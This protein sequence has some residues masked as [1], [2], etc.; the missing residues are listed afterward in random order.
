MSSK[1]FVL[2]LVL[3]AG[4]LAAEPPTPDPNYLFEPLTKPLTGTQ[5][6]ES[7]AEPEPEPDPDIEAEAAHFRMLFGEPSPIE[8]PRWPDDQYDPSPAKDAD[9]ER[10]LI[11]PMP[12]GGAMVFRRIDTGNHEGWLGDQQIR[13]GS[14]NVNDAPIDYRYSAYIAGTFTGGTQDPR[15]NRYYYLGKYE[16]TDLQYRV[17]TG[18]CPDRL[19]G[20]RPA[21]SISWYD[22]VDFTR[23][24]T[25]WLYEM[26]RERLPQE[27]GMPGYLRLPTEVEWEY[28]AR[29]GLEVDEEQFQTALFPMTEGSIE[30]YAWIRESVSSSF[31]PRPSGSLKPNPLGLYDM[32]GNVSELVFD[33]FRLSSQ[34]HLHGQPGGFMVKGGHFRS[35]RNTLG[36]SWRQEHPHF[37][38]KTGQPNR[39]DTVGFRVAISAPVLTSELRIKAIDQEWESL[40]E[41][42]VLVEEGA[43]QAQLSE[44]QSDLAA[45]ET[46]LERCLVQAGEHALPPF[47]AAPYPRVEPP[48]RLP[49]WWKVR[50]RLDYMSTEEIRQHALWFLQ[51]QDPDKALLLFKQAARQGEAWSALAIGAMYDPRLFDAEDFE[52]RQ[53]AFSKPNP[54]M[55]RCWYQ[56][57]QEL[58]E[59]RAK[60]HLSALAQYE[61]RAAPETTTEQE[62]AI[63]S[64]EQ[65]LEQ[66][67][68]TDRATNDGSE[69]DNP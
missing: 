14:Q 1:P 37:N 7:E 18:P 42:S 48:A 49:A 2:A 67:G 65:I 43:C 60:L 28:A 22:A 6:S 20:R 47:P 30:D 23:R 52:P 46:E 66:Y 29:G 54:G 62:A 31:E 25:E 4:P 24:Y 17:M 32:L 40:A 27:D 21:T 16:V 39:L 45:A 58:G 5:A 38:P 13:L 51:A 41:E 64:C 35:W 9:K 11:L 53:S 44:A 26:A 36:S 69:E 57:S 12:C 56:L 59:W 3:C 68:P 34:G 55:A 8:V 50:E 19:R 61:E 33:L 15:A 10:E 63:T